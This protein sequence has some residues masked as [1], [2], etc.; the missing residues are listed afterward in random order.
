[1]KN[2]IYNQSA[3]TLNFKISHNSSEIF[4]ILADSIIC[5]VCSL[6]LSEIDLS[7]KINLEI[8]SL[9]TIF[10]SLILF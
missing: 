3:F 2:F 6:S 8:T 1:M 5:L 7:D 9:E 10:I 4:E